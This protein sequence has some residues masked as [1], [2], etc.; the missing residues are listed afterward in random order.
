MSQVL[1]ESGFDSRT[2]T[3]QFFLFNLLLCIVRCCSHP[4][5]NTVDVVQ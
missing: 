3:L 1:A 4:R 5:H 2:S